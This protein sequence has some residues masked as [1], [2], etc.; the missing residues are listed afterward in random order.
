ML[1]DSALMLTGTIVARGVLRLSGHEEQE[2]ETSPSI[3]GTTVHVK[4]TLP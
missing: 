1:A 2:V 3:L 4:C